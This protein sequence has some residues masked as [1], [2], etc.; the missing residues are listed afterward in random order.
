MFADCFFR[1]YCTERLMSLW[2]ILSFWEVHMVVE[3]AECSITFD[4][5]EE[6]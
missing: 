6:A 2:C 5:I 1:C 4:F 3:G